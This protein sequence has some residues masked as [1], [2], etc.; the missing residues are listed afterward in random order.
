MEKDDSPRRHKGLT[1]IMACRSVS[2]G[3][4]AREGLLKW[5][6]AHVRKVK[7]QP[8][9]D[10]H[11]E[12]FQKNVVVEV[13]YADLASIKTVIQFGERISKK[14][15]SFSAIYRTHPLTSSVTPLNLDIHMSRI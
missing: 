3:Q 7:S 13:E 2:K 10:G 4:K 15:V 1:L 8:G 11:A 14:C 9:Y 12:S 6:E 5:F